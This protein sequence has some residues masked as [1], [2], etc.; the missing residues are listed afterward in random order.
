MEKFNISYSTK[1][2]PLPSHNDY[3]Q[4]LIERTEQFLHRMRWKAH[5]FLNPDTT[6][7][8]KETYGFKSTKNPPSIEELKDFEDDML[9]MIQ[10]VKFKQVNNPFLNRLKENTDHIKNEPKL[11]I[12]ADKTTNFYKLEPSTYNDLLEKNITKSYEKALPE[13][14][15]AIHKE[16][17]DIATKLG[18]DD[19]VDTTTDKDAFI[20]LKTNTSSLSFSSYNIKYSLYYLRY[21]LLYQPYF[22]F[23]SHCICN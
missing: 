23:H 22:K 3:L 17:K 20:T 19:R 21:M 5:S 8:T 18:I 1:N 15:Q 11:L 12:A 9:K 6:S 13:T 2:I 14:T 4:R 10:S 7:F 16:N